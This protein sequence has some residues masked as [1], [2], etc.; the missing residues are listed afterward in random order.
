M[1][2][3]DS[4]WILGRW[5]HIDGIIRCIKWDVTE[6]LDVIPCKG[7]TFAHDVRIY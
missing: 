5:Y 7:I 3:N 4:V 2:K 6:G 1:C